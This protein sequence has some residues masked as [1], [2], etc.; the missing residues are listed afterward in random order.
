MKKAIPKLMVLI[1][2]IAL[3]GCAATQL[4]KIKSNSERADV[5]REVNEGEIPTGFGDLLVECSIKTHLK[6]LYTVEWG[7]TFHGESNYPF[8]LNIDG[9]SITWEIDGQKD[10]APKYDEKGQRNPERGE[11]MKYILKKR[12]RLAAGL[13]KLFFAL[14]SESIYKEMEISVKENQLHRLEF[15]PVY[16]GI[17]LYYQHFLNGIRGLEISQHPLAG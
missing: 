5:F 2:V 9:Q 15:R 6:G 12:I 11:G 10:I 3:G 7:E 17:S 1:L 8:L 13:H 4:I 14:P 16:R